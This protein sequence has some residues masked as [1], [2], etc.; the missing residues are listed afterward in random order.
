MIIGRTKQCVCATAKHM[1]VTPEQIV[2]RNRRRGNVLARH[3]AMYVTRRA[4][5][6]SYPMIGQVM[7]RDHTTVM[8]AVAKIERLR[9]SD[10]ELDATVSAILAEVLAP[11]E[12][13]RQPVEAVVPEE[14]VA[15]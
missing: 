1:S 7:N 13:M 3:V 2:G 5:G 9:Q 6:Q 11:R 14:V 15:P 8:F 10:A 12:G 4:F